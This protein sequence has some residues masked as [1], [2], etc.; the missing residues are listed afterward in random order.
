MEALLLFLALLLLDLAA[1]R[2]GRDSR[3]PIGHPEWCRRSGWLSRPLQPRRPGGGLPRPVTPPAVALDQTAGRR[4][5]LR[6][7]TVRPRPALGP[8]LPILGLDATPSP[9]PAPGHGAASSR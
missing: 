1:L 8:A 7:P 2:W 9:V 3:D 6:R 4:P 5:A